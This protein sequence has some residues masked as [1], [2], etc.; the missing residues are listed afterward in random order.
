MNKDAIKIF[1]IIASSCILSGSG[2]VGTL[3][4]INK[5]DDYIKEHPV[6]KQ[7]N[8]NY[9]ILPL[10]PKNFPDNYSKSIMTKGK[11]SEYLKDLDEIIPIL[12][13]LRSSIKNNENLQKYNAMA[14]TLKIYV[15]YINTKYKDKPES[16]FE[17][18]KEILYVNN[19][20]QFISAHWLE[21]SRNIHY[22]S[23]FSGFDSIYPDVIKDKSFQELEGRITNLL[24][25]LKE[26]AL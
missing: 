25:D 11:Y 10:A 6:Q 14:G 19:Q 16:N 5:R 24:A 1:A 21:S 3:P 23:N 18:F 17:T 12:E 26:N 20:A 7:K 13:K 2:Y 15:N 4:D 8:V 22:I 9:E